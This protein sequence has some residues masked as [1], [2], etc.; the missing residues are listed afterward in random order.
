M[1]RSPVNCNIG[2][3]PLD[4]DKA[5]HTGK[6]TI[7]ETYNP[8]VGLT[9]VTHQESA[10]NSCRTGADGRSTIRRGKGLPSTRA[11]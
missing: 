1:S 4:K 2:K 10:T 3:F 9:S 6:I 5:T 8:S 11:R 7:E